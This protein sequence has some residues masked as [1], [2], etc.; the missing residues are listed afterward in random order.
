MTNAERQF[1]RLKFRLWYFSRRYPTVGL[2]L[3]WAAQLATSGF[4]S[5]YRRRLESLGDGLFPSDRYERAF[6]VPCQCT[7][8]T[9]GA[10]PDDLRGL[11]LLLNH[12]RIPYHR[13]GLRDVTATTAAHSQQPALFL[14]VGAT[15]NA[16]ASLSAMAPRLQVVGFGSRTEE[17][18][19]V[20]RLSALPAGLLPY[21]EGLRSALTRAVVQ[22]LIHAEFPIVTGMLPP[23]AGMRVDDVAGTTCNRYVPELNERGWV[24]NL[25]IFLEDFRPEAAALLSRLDRA[26]RIECSPHAQNAY[27]FLFF[28]Y[29]DG[30]PFAIDRFASMWSEAVRQFDEWGLAVCPV[31]NAHFHAFSQSAYPVLAA[32]GVRYVFSELAPD[33]VDA[34]P[35]PHYLP[36]GDPICTT[37]Q[38][39]AEVMWQIHSGDPTLNCNLPASTYDFL[40]HNDGRDVRLQAGRKI[41]DRIALSLETGFAAW[42]TT[43]EYLLDRLSQADTAVMLD[44]SDRRLVGAT[45]P[46]VK[47]PMSAIGRACENHSTA[48]IDSVETTAT[49][50]R[51]SLRG[52]ASGGDALAILGTG[53]LALREVPAFNGSHFEEIHW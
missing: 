17:G 23:Q 47:A 10:S 42:A 15:A 25:G 41:A 3:R 16:V 52:G 34:R 37:G 1:H 49:G 38:P 24:P 12:L 36:S 19:M 11:T 18:P 48:V 28:N 5:G 2:P 29:K 53:K 45:V 8:V 51:V 35:G 39:G 6:T 31:L 26:G 43:H 22:A 32:S 27:E 46:F 44:E 14:M 40:M 20:T 7:V 33:H 9:D 13:G 50:A 30:E 4:E 21:R